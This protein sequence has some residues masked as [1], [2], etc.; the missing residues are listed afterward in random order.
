MRGS[1]R[2]RTAAASVLVVGAGV[3]AAS[4]A[5]S[6]LLHNTLLDDTNRAAVHG[7]QDVAAL[8]QAGALPDRLPIPSDKGHEQLLVQVVGP[9]GQIVSASDRM[10]GAPVM[11][12]GSPATEPVWSGRDQRR[13]AWRTAGRASGRPTHSVSAVNWSTKTTV[14]PP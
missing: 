7:A 10:V 8:I 6:A 11:L 2:A 13:A 14:L 1:M 12:P 3:V 5:V 9:T 4:V